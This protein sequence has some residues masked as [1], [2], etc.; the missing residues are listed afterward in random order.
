[1]RRAAA[2]ALSLLLAAALPAAAHEFRM[3]ILMPPGASAAAVESAFRIAADETDAHAL[4]ESD[5]HLGG[6]DVYLGLF[7]PGQEADL[8][9]FAPD[10]VAAIAGDG[11]EAARIAAELGAAWIA[12]P[13]PDTPRARAMLARTI[14]GRER[15]FARHFLALTGE[16][17][18]ANAIA[19]YLV[20][21]IADRAVRALGG[22]DDK[23][24][25]QALLAE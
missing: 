25:L 14:D 1:M 5:G 24:A 13:D 18:D 16:E 6:L 12:P 11:A 9:A 4:Q 2:L 20:A 22:T 15:P 21:R 23:P 7:G 19:T 17:A 10:I 8:R 3:A